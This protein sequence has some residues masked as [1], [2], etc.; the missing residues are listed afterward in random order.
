MNLVNYFNSGRKSKEGK[1]VLFN[2]FEDIIF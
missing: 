1:N 2:N